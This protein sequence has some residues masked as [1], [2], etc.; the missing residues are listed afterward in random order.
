MTTEKEKIEIL[1]KKIHNYDSIVGRKKIK[2][3]ISFEYVFEKRTSIVYQNVYDA[4][5]A[6]TNPLW[7]TF[8]NKHN[9]NQRLLLFE[10]INYYVPKNGIYV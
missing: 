9:R 3:M 5:R 6:M 8:L 4:L 2:D 10:R 1:R 7:R